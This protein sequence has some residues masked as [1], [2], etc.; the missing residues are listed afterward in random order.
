MAKKALSKK[1]FKTLFTKR[2]PDPGEASAT[3]AEKK[4]DEKK[5][6]K[7]PK[8]KIKSKGSPS[9]LKQQVFR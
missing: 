3:S 9:F 4:T 7:L 6:F 5:R 8:L 1:S 2:E